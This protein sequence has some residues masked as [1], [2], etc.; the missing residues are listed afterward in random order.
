MANKSESQE[1]AKL[2]IRELAFSGESSR[3]SVKI[4]VSPVLEV[5]VISVESISWRLSISVM[6]P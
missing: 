5:R 3:A 6:R 1:V 4:K 2:S